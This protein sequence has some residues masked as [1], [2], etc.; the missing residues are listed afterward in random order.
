M[1]A[2]ETG[3][4]TRLFITIL[5]LTMAMMVMKAVLAPTPPIDTLA[6]SDNDDIMRLLSVRALLEGQ[7]WY[8]MTQ[9][10]MLPPA[11]AREAGAL[12]ADGEFDLTSLDGLRSELVET[13]RSG[14][15]LRA[16][17]HPYTRRLLSA[18]PVPDPREQTERRAARRGDRV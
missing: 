11:R 12:Y 17:E 18:L 6:V 5:V 14:D 4:E 13:G 1:T 10:R 7:A 3:R 2:D 15:V 9:Y 16:P 8:D